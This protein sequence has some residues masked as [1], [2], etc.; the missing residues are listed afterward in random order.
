MAAP[1]LTWPFLSLLSLM[2]SGSPLL[3]SNLFKRNKSESVS[4]TQNYITTQNVTHTELSTIS[5]PLLAGYIVLHEHLEER[6]QTVTPYRH[7]LSSM[8]LC[9]RVWN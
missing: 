6:Q 4:D 5:F 8:H 7:G 1:L 9:T 3:P 2:D